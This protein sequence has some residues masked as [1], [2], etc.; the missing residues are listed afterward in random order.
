MGMVTIAES[1]G[2]DIISVFED[3]RLAIVDDDITAP[4]VD[5]SDVIDDLIAE[6]VD[7]AHSSALDD[8]IS[9]DDSVSFDVK[10]FGDAEIPSY[11]VG[12]RLI[13]FWHLNNQLHPGTVKSIYDKKILYFL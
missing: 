1:N 9:R 3:T 10:H 11:L 13:T 6:Y 2:C 12:E 5:S 4:V 7:C 8:E